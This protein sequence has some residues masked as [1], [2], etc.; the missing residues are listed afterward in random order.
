MATVGG[1]RVKSAGKQWYKDS[2]QANET[3]LLHIW[4]KAREKKDLF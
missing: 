3:S 1:G 2:P 4:W